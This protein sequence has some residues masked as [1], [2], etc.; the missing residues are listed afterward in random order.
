[1]HLSPAYLFLLTA[2]RLPLTA[3]RLPLTAYR[4]PLNVDNYN[5]DTTYFMTV[6]YD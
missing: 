1:L 4:L 2:Y 5:K 3:Y 6:I